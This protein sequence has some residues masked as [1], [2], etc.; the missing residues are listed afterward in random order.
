MHGMNP[1]FTS[2]LKEALLLWDMVVVAAKAAVL[3]EDLL[4]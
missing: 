1:S 2:D 4:Y 3:L